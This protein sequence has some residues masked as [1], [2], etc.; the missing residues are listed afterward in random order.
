VA[1]NNFVFGAY[2]HCKWPAVNGIVADPTGKSFLI[3][4]VN[5]SG[6]AVR[7]SLRHKER[8]VELHGRGVFFGSLEVAHGL[9]I[10]HPNFGLC[11][12]GRA[13]NQV[14]GSFSNGSTRLRPCVPG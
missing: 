14:S 11:F 1:G 5:A 10:A 8:A 4:L 7:F 3:S 2:T 12:E 6:K 9:E 13:A